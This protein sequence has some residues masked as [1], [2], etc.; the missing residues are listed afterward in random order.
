[1]NQ[2]NSKQQNKGREGEKYIAAQ[3]TR[4]GYKVLYVGGCQLESIT[5]EKY[6]TVDLL[7]FKN[8]RSFWVQAKNKEPRRKYPDTGMEF[9]RYENLVKHQKESGLP[10]LVLFTDNTKKIYGEWLNNLPNCKS[11]HGGTYNNRDDC[12]MIYWLVEKLKN[13]QDLLLC[14]Q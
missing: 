4:M 12:E 13:Y 9:W 10:V 11:P 5:G 14:R 6:Y 8:G 3:L 2:I 7:V 1:M